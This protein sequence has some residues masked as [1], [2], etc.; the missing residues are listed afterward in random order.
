MSEYFMFV[1]VFVAR[2]IPV[3]DS[4]SD[5]LS[6]VLEETGGLGVDIVVDAG[7]EY[8]VCQLKGSL[9]EI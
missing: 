8:T 7:G 9:R 1:C 5:L 6:D 4:S 2:V 3:F